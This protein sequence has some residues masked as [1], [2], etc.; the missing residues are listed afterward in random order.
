LPK[1]EGSLTRKLPVRIMHEIPIVTYL[2]QGS[3][4][5]VITVLYQAKGIVRLIEIMINI[6]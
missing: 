3:F 4:R 2:K 1:L 6:W 5:A